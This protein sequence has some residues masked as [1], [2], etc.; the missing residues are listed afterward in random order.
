M[1]NGNEIVLG[2]YLRTV[3][4]KLQANWSTDNDIEGKW[5]VLKCALCEGAR[6]ELGY[7]KKRQPDWYRENANIIM[8]LL[9]ERN[10]LYNQWLS[11]RQEK[12]TG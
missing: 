3:E 8:P 1:I 9:S 7:A 4:D 5:N 2:R 6:L 10:K 11:T 12:E